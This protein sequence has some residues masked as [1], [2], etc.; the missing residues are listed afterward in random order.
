MTEVLASEITP[1]TGANPF[2]SEDN[3]AGSAMRTPSYLRVSCALN[4]YRQYRRL[5][6][7]GTPLRSPPSALPL[8]NVQRRLLIFN[9]PDSQRFIF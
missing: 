5:N 6:T 3:L 8:S 9:S 7:S 2:R 4:G 1:L